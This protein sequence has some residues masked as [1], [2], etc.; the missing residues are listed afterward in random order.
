M[1][2]AFNRRLKRWYEQHIADGSAASSGA[3]GSSD[4][5]PASSSSVQGGVFLEFDN[6]DAG[7]PSRQVEATLRLRQDRG[8]LPG[9]G[10]PGADDASL[11]DTSD[12][13]Q[14][15]VAVDMSYPRELVC[16]DVD[17]V[18]NVGKALYIVLLEEVLKEISE[19]KDKLNRRQNHSVA[20]KA[21]K[22]TET[23]EEAT[24]PPQLPTANRRRRLKPRRNRQCCKFCLFKNFSGSAAGT[25][26]YLH[27]LQSEH[28]PP[29]V[30]DTC[31]EESLFL[32]VTE[33]DEGREDA[34]W[35]QQ[36][37]LRSWC[38]LGDDHQQ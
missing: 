33:E 37:F 20:G 17:G 4:A 14:S 13:S 16:T 32:Y 28:V 7:F 35:A 12:D 1:T 5:P 19:V 3:C 31:T 23:N 25:I 2:T 10:R 8:H 18:V 34:S 30:P 6:D 27:H 9:G 36:S 21:E 24:S 38:Y 29:A 22:P 15:S 26:T 11:S